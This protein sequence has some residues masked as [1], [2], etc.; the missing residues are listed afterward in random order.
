MEKFSKGDIQE[1]KIRVVYVP[2][3]GTGSPPYE[4]YVNGTVR[5]SLVTA[6]NFIDYLQHDDAPPAYG[7]PS[8]SY[9]S[10]GQD[11]GTPS[12]RTAATNSG[13]AS[14][15]Q[16]RLQ[17]NNDRGG[18]QDSA[19]TVASS[20]QST[21]VGAASTVANTIPISSEDLRAQ[22]SEAKATIAKLR[23]QGVL[24]QRKSNEGNQDFKEQSPPGMK[25]IQ[26]STSE[27]VPVSIV[28]GLCLLSF[29]LAYF[30][31]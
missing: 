6:D 22:L 28:A 24:G 1:R 5:S 4:A 17:D 9:S 15:I 30:F 20:I 10:P 29:L 26:Q 19:P 11:A 23:Q 8:P 14:H 13:S 12:N 27:G 18:G 16:P 7:S 3:E 21:M 31:F 2:S 25:A